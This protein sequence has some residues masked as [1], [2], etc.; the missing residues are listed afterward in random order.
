MRIEDNSKRSKEDFKEVRSIVDRIADKTLEQLEKEGIFVFPEILKDADDLTREQMILQSYNDSYQ[1]GN[2]MGFIGVGDERLV[3]RSRFSEGDND[4]LFQYLLEKVME[5]YNLIKF[6]TSVNPDEQVFNLLLFLFPRYLQKAMRK[7][8]FKTYIRREYNDDN[9]RGTIDINRHIRV[10]TP[11]AGKIAYSQRE[12]SYDNYLMELIRHTIEFI[13]GKAYGYRLL[14]NV[15][16]EVKLVVGATSEYRATDREKIIRLNM[17]N[18]IRHAYFHEYRDL[19]RLCILILRNEKHQFGMGTRKM[20]GILF[21]GAWLW[22]EYVNTLLKDVGEG[23]EHPRN[24]AGKGSEW[25]FRTVDEFDLFGNK[26]KSGSLQGKIYPDFIGKDKYNRVIADAKY[27]PMDNIGNKDYLQV[28]AYMFRFDAKKG[29]Y[30]Y[31]EVGLESDL[32]L[33]LNRGV[34]FEKNVV[35]RDDISVIKHGLKIPNDVENYAEFC[36]MMDVAEKEFVSE[37]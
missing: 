30:L 5:N 18:D 37:M 15:K 2:V 28:L 13:K 22:E 27:K 8:L 34:S 23:F 24:K 3:I 4:Y 35:P 21:D 20:Y 19:Q 33:R 17:K 16:D 1:S 11:F 10:N 12:Y 25:L 14:N 9:V 29:Y 36:E 6:D 7:G 32:H 31:P 26:V